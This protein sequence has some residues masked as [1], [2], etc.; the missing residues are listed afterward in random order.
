VKAKVDES[1]CIGCGLCEQVCPAVFAM[2]DDVAKVQAD[3]VPDGQADSCRE[4]V[5]AC[6][7]EAISIEE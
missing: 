4:A 3:P 6:P 1:L 2:E 7:V 5:D